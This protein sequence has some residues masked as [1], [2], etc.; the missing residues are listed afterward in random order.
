M[1]KPR[2]RGGDDASE[3]P[4]QLRQS[5]RA[6]VSTILSCR[7]RRCCRPR[8]PSWPPCTLI[9]KRRCANL[10]SRKPHKALAVFP[11]KGSWLLSGADTA[12]GRKTRP[13][14]LRNPIRGAVVLALTVMTSCAPPRDPRA[15]HC[16][17]CRASPMKACNGAAISSVLMMRTMRGRT[18]LVL[19][20][21]GSFRYRE[22][23]G[24][25][26]QDG[27]SAT[28]RAHGS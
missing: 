12:Q 16:D 8:L 25:M 5:M 22:H 18:D 4:A 6:A 9:E 19:L 7:Q 26:P 27:I 24:H 15:C 1:A 14:R 13:G 28:A 3:L 11:P 21:L 23:S 20:P 2:D 10:S 17:P